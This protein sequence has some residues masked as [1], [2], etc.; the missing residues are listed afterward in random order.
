MF[1][2]VK[3]GLGEFMHGFYR[4]VVPTTTPMREFVARGF[5][6]C[7]AW[8]PSR[9]I[10]KVEEM[11]SAWQRNDTQQS[12][13]RPPKMPV[14][15]VAVAKDYV[16]ISGDFGM[17]ISD[18]TEVMI[19]GDAKNRY[20][21]MRMV[22]GEVRAQIAVFAQDEP[23]AKSIAAQFLL[24]LGSP[25]NRGFYATF[26]F[27]GVDNK[28]PVQFESRDSPAMN[29]D[30]GANNLAVLAIDLT[31]RCS[32]PIFSAPT[33]G[34]SNDGQGVPGTDDPAGYPL[35]QEVDVNDKERI[36]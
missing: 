5:P 12:D 23:T 31:L 10:D 16:P 17:Q 19:P 34:E 6:Y 11:L 30:T 29:I 20:F 27:A 32:V 15:L 7:V 18:S 4:S 13:T 14:V 33:E 25:S 36:S 22:M 35:V 9:M 28:F 3:A 1:E 26:P 24:Y 2:P 21:E 8:A